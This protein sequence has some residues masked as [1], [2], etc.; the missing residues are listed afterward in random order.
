ML[1][2][3]TT[4][5]DLVRLVRE[6]DGTAFGIL[7]QRHFTFVSSVAHRYAT[8]SDDIVSE[9]FLRTFHALQSGKGP[10][11]GFRSYV[12]RAVHN[13]AMNTTRDSRSLAWESSALD[14]VV[15]SDPDEENRRLDANLALEAFAALP[16]QW[17][18]LIW[19]RDVRNIPPRVIAERTSVPVGDISSML[20]R[21]REGLRQ[22]WIRA[23]LSIRT[24]RDQDCF[25]TRNKLPA[26]VRSKLPVASAVKVRGHCDR[27]PECSD[28][29]VE[30]HRVNEII[31]CAFPHVRTRKA[32]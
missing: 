29:L 4:D 9:A 5:D 2:D 14:A 19:L 28:Q 12:I 26:F 24:V 17:Q 10:T 3:E 21:A 25:V 20:Y 23:H 6:G 32:R 27:C 13:I 11:T 31:S 18:Q 16:S 1:D 8:D 30:A 7:W 22:E 15:F